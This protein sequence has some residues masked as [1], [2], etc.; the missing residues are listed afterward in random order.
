MKSKFVFTEDQK[1]DINEIGQNCNLQFIILY[2]SFA[3][4]H[5]REDS[6]MDIAVKGYKEISFQEILDI[7][8]SLSRLFP[9]KNLDVKSLHKVDPFFRFQVMRDG[10]LL[11]GN[12]T[13]YLDFKAYAYRDYQESKSLLRLQSQLVEKRLSYLKGL[14]D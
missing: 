10:I 14:Y 7:F 3:T 9:G 1:K 4:N 5:A 6:D 2:G 8:D 12:K 11:Y 13:D